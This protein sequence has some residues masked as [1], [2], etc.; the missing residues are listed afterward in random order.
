MVISANDHGGVLSMTT[1][2]EK[3]RLAEY[4]HSEDEYQIS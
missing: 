2:L 1:I 3:M 4:H